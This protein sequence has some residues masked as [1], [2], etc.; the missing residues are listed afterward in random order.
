MCVNERISMSIY[1][2]GL[3]DASVYV[4]V[5]VHVNERGRGTCIWILRCSDRAIKVPPRIKDETK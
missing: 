5:Y 1:V 2:H 3:V 4:C